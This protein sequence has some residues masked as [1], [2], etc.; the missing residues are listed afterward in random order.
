MCPARE[1]WEIEMPT[2]LGEELYL[3]NHQRKILY[4]LGKVVRYDREGH[5]LISTGGDKEI[6]IPWEHAIANCLL[7]NID[8]GPLELLIGNFHTR[9]HENNYKRVHVRD[10]IITGREL[11][12]KHGFKYY[13]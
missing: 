7:Q 10:H 2:M 6:P 9:V 12:E 11:A 1:F 5:L 8:E 13:E 3:V 4:G